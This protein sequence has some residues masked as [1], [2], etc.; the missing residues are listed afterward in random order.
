MSA[1]EDFE[2]EMGVVTREAYLNDV[3]AFAAQRPPEVTRADVATTAAGRFYQSSYGR[4]DMA[5]LLGVAVMMLAE[6][7]RRR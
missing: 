6:E 4:D 5:A 7:R 1:A 3:A 2:V